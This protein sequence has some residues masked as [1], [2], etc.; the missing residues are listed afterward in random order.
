LAL[1]AVD[2]GLGMGVFPDLKLI[3]LIPA[4]RLTANY[5]KRLH[6]GIEFNHHWLMHIRNPAYRPPR[7][8]PALQLAAWWSRRS[9]PGEA[10]Q[11][12]NARDRARREVAQLIRSAP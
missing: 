1:T 6:E 4:Q 10:R 11:I 2:M 5:L 9:L 7:H 12:E 8:E 3:H